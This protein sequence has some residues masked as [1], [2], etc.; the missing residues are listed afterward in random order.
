MRQMFE[1]IGGDSDVLSSEKAVSALRQHLEVLRTKQAE[2]AQQ[3]EQTS[4]ALHKLVA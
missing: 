1:I 3:I 2:I 4:T